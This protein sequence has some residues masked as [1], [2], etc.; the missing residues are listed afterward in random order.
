LSDP[1]HLQAIEARQA[2]F[3]LSASPAGRSRAEKPGSSHRQLPGVS[4]DF[5]FASI[6]ENE[7]LMYELN[8]LC[9]R[10]LRALAD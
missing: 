5:W 10:R 4:W 7:F 2:G 1:L 8:E 9:P 6:S 3:Q